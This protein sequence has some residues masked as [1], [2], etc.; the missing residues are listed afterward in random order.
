L[1][2]NGVGADGAKSIAENLS[3]LTSLDLR[4]NNIG[5]DGAKAIA[6]NLSGLTSLELNDNEIGAD[7][8]KAIAGNLSGL[9]SLNLDGNSIGADGAKSIAEN[10]SGLASLNLN[11]NGI[12]ADGAKAIA[13]NLSGLT[14]L[15]LNDN[16]IGADGAKAIAAN[17]SGL[18]SLNLNGNSIGDE[19]A[20]VIAEN[21]LG[22]L[23]LGLDSNEIGD[24][25]ARALFGNRLAES[26]ARLSLRNN[27]ITILPEEI[28]ISG[29]VRGILSAYRRYQSGSTAPL[30]EA[31]LLVVGNEAVG[32]TS[33]VRFLRLGV[34]RRPDEQKTPGVNAHERIETHNWSPADRGPRLNIW[35][36]GGQEIMH[37]THQFFL[38]RRSLYLL[39]L[40]NRREDDLSVYGW[41]RTIANRAGESPVIIVINKCD[42][43]SENLHLDETELLRDW[44]N[45]VGIVRTSCND[46]DKAHQSIT[47]L[48]D[49]I[50][51]VL[52][53]HPSL[54]HVRE[55]IPASWQRL[56]EAVRARA[57][58]EKIFSHHDF[59]KLCEAGE[60]AEAIEDEAEQ[61]LLLGLLHDLGTVVAYGLEP[62]AA[63]ALREVK[64]L[65]PNWLTG[66]IYTILNSGLVARQGGVFSREQLSELLDPA[67]YGLERWEFIITMMQHEGVGLCFPVAGSNDTFLVPEALPKGE[68][69]LGNWPDD[70]LRFRL[71]YE[72]LPPG[73]IPRFVVRAH[74]RLKDSQTRW[75]TGAVLQ[76]AECTILV[77]GLRKL[78]QRIDILVDGPPAMRRSALN[79]ILDDFKFVHDLNPEAKPKELVPIPDAPQLDVAYS[80]LC[81]LEELYGADHRFLP[82]GADK[83]Y[84]VGDLLDGVRR[85]SLLS[86]VVGRSEP[87]GESRD[88]Q[89]VSLLEETSAQDWKHKVALPTNQWVLLLSDLHIEESTDIETMRQTL[90]E[91]LRG[92]PAGAQSITALVISGDLT[93]RATPEEFACARKF[94]QGLIRDIPGL[95]SESTVVVPGNHDVDWAHPDVYRLSSGSR[96]SGISDDEYISDGKLTVVRDARAYQESWGN[97]SRGV[98][99]PL[100]DRDYALEPESQV[101]LFNL[102]SARL[103][104]V[105]FNSAWNT[106]QYSPDSSQII[107]AAVNEASRRLEE[108]D[109]NPLLIGVWHH[110]I[111]GNEKIENDAFVQRLRNA[112][113]QLCLHGHIHESK[114]DLLGYLHP[115]KI[116]VIGTGSFGAP[117]KDRKE[118]TPR[119][120]QLLEF[121]NERSRLRVHTRGLRK[122][123]G[124]WD[125]WYEWPNPED[126]DKR[127][128]HYDIKLDGSS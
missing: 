72:F 60:G 7:G 69:Y 16:E 114:A 97:F 88:L 50:V 65:D 106:A 45:V 66:A 77:R 64:L 46:D 87:S 15:E 125:P 82:E 104:F 92:G 111:T 28:L 67:E 48:R 68:P 80:H 35:D 38:T 94:I 56:K 63:A 108:V 93:N 89:G 42:G 5:A 30:N 8:A 74:H 29:D 58:A 62:G 128:P 11:S 41:L 70:S 13:E 43:G 117:S 25:G 59:E 84:R 20:K 9:L 34:P 86:Q 2:D 83:E 75:R 103:C 107:D 98:Y 21:L 3:G 126:S 4:Y 52:N 100:Y 123:G 53:E 81:K 99:Q 40:E 110:P 95:S 55:P 36:F 71:E 96:P 115:R 116:H 54:S 105:T 14:L 121:K 18:L 109:G 85:Q 12:G 22:L 6:E 76:A 37:G 90:L 33:L 32:K 49:R 10:L 17:L 39:V 102:P 23:S 122:S 79:I 61:R 47:K 31:K 118:S 78:E 19:G 91:D 1:N 44:P 119:L 124:A 26:L 113:I 57:E 73:L 127:L 24:D 27:G 120:Y 101:D 112:G 51:S